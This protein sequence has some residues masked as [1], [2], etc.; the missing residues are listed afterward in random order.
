VV[1][2][3]AQGVAAAADFAVEEVFAPP[4]STDAAS[5]F[6]FLEWQPFSKVSTLAH[7]LKEVT[8]K[9]TFQNFLPL[10]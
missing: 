4:Y 2:T 7:L 8:I 6:F 1:I 10:Q 3:Q 9:R 5:F